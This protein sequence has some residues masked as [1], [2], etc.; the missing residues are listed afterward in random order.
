MPTAAYEPWNQH[1]GRSEIDIIRKYRRISLPWGEYQM[2]SAIISS[3]I[4]PQVRAY[5]Y[6]LKY[7]YMFLNVSTFPLFHAA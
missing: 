6:Y 1:G 3:N 4:L 5:V 7:V 2:V